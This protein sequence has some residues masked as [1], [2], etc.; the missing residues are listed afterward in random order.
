MRWVIA[1]GLGLAL[2]AEAREVAGKELPEAVDVGDATLRL[3]GAAVQRK[4]FWNIYS[5]ALYLESPT[6]SP[7]QAVATDQVKRIHLRMLRDASRA[8]VADALRNGVRSNS[9]NLG[10]IEERLQRLLSALPDVKLGDEITVTY[11][12]GKGTTLHSDRKGDLVV[13]GKDFADAFFRIWLGDSSGIA[14]VRRGLM[15]GS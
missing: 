9:P 6:R 2:S 7:Q 8:Q 13:E 1:L 5:V 15:K 3:N 4:F 10:D 12:P 11:V 14:R